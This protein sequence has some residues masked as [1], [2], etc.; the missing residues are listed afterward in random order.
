MS[1]KPL[2]PDFNWVVAT[3][4]SKAKAIAEALELPNIVR[5]LSVFPQDLSNDPQVRYEHLLNYTQTHGRV[6]LLTVVETMEAHYLGLADESIIGNRTS[7]LVKVGAFE[8]M[9]VTDSYYLSRNRR[10]S[11][12]PHS[13]NLKNV[14]IG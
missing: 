12:G 8:A 5:D 14:M 3:S 6:T 4:I 10:Y 1:D 2:C 7:F 9:G 11:P 13:I